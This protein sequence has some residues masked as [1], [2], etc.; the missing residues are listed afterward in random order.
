MLETMIDPPE[1]DAPVCPV[2]G[3]EVGCWD[4]KIYQDEN[5]HVCGCSYCLTAYDP[6]EVLK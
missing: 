4:D 5:G 3:H 2:C 6:W 1:V